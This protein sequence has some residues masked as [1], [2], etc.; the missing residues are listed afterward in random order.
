MKIDDSVRNKGFNH[1]FEQEI[2]IN[3]RHIMLVDFDVLK[4]FSVK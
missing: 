4:G 1:F 3:P 2:D